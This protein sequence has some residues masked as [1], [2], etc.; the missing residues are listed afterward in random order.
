M[1]GSIS[2]QWNICGTQGC[3]C[4]DPNHPVK[5]GPYYQLS[6][7]YR[8]KSRTEFVRKEFLAQV[9]KEI[10]FA[11]MDELVARIT[12][13]VAQIRGILEHDR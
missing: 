7:T 9:R 12:T 6:Y 10:K 11:D 13:D 5:H 8:G 3:K 1:P 4:K 2:E